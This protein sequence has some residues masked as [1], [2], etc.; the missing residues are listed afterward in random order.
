MNPLDTATTEELTNELKRRSVHGIVAVSGHDPKNPN[1][2]GIH[3]WGSSMWAMGACQFIN[4]RAMR[5][6]SHNSDEQN[7]RDGQNDD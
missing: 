2:F 3:L 6:L 1:D 5:E 4:A 7:H